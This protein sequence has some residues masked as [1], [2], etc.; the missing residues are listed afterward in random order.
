MFLVIVDAYSKWIEVKTTNVAT[1]TATIAIL[2]ELFAA[3]GTPVTIVSDN[4]PQFTSVEFKTFL[5]TNGVKYHKLSAPYHPADSQKCY[6]QDAI[7]KR[8]I[9]A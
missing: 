9:T 4:A 6:L 3:Y 1:S 5:Q 2:D 8:L 7:Y